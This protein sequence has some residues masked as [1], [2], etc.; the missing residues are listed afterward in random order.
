MSSRPVSIQASKLSVGYGIH[1]VVRDI[2]M[3]VAAGDLVA[4]DL[5]AGPAFVATLHALQSLGAAMLPLNRRLSEPERRA[6]LDHA[7]PGAL[8]DE[9][10]G[11][12]HV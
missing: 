5:P 9:Q 1:T 8:L 6:I 4:V 7:A 11:R 2:D 3:S 10:I 12:A